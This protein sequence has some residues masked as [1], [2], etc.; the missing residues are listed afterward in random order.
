MKDM[1]EYPNDLEGQMT[2]FDFLPAPSDLDELPEEEMVRIVGERTGLKF[3]L[4]DLKT[5]FYQYETK[6]GKAKIT[7]NYSNYFSEVC[8]G[9]RFI[10]VGYMNGTGGA[11][12]PCDS[13]DDA[14]EII[15]RYI[16]R[17]RREK[18]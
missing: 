16:E 9:K 1:S 4:R 17:I 12:A 15:K 11:G 8:N 6:I 13:V 18:R 10:S 2:I 14:V 5:E 3:Q 7:V